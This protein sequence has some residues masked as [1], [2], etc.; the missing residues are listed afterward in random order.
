MARAAFAASEDEIGERRGF[1]PGRR[2][3]FMGGATAPAAIPS[4]PTNRAGRASNADSCC[5]RDSRIGRD[6]D[7]LG[8][9]QH[10][11]GGHGDRLRRAVDH[12]GRAQGHRRGGQ[13]RALGPGFRQRPDVDRLGR[14]RHSHGPGRRAHR[15]ALDGDVRRRDDRRRAWRCRLRVRRGRFIS[16]TVCSSA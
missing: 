5:N 8:R 6:A 13:R 2:E 16:A 11:P 12:R 10:R 4:G 7:V 1:I 3:N 14:R 15:H 9:R